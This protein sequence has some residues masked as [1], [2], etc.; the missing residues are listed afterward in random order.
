MASV[1]SCLFTACAVFDAKLR[2]SDV[3]ADLEEVWSL[4]GVSGCPQCLC[5]DDQL[6]DLDHSAPVRTFAETMDVICTA[7]KMLQERGNIT[8]SAK[9]LREFRLSRYHTKLWNPFLL[10]PHCDFDAF[11]QDHL[12]GMYVY[13][14]P[15]MYILCVV[16]L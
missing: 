1:C 10:L 4:L 12:H 7:R 3:C 13:W 11:P 9:F 2:N 15:L 6:A 14:L 8:N 16:H 5:K